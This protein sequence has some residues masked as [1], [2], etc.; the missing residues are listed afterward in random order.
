MRHSTEIAFSNSDEI[1]QFLK[2][3]KASHVTQKEKGNLNSR[4]SIKGIEFVLKTFQQRQLQ[5]QIFSLGN[6]TQHLIKK[7]IN[8]AQ[9]AADTRRL[10]NISQ[11]ISW[12]SHL[13]WSQLSESKS[14]WRHEEI[15]VQTN[16][17]HRHRCK[18]LQQTTS[19]P[20][21]VIKRL[22]HHDQAEFTPAC[23][24]GAKFLKIKQ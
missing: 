21:P 11:L 23:K 4:L 13:F 3:S 16:I 12:R 10:E 24:A 2:R 7:I 1:H 17:H 5:V 18:I 8:Y 9:L 6:S 20:N 15:K 22:F 19:K 14:R